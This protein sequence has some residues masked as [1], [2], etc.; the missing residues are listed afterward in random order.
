MTTRDEGVTRHEDVRTEEDV[1][2]GRTVTIVLVA[3]IAFSVLLSLASYGIQRERE[4]ALRPSGEFPEAKA[5]PPRELPGV[6]RYLFETVERAPAPNRIQREAL[7]AWSWQDPTR[8]TVNLPIGHAMRLVV[9]QGGA[10]TPTTP[11]TP[12]TSP[13]PT[14]GGTP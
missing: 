3:T 12:T 7:E 6:E 13:T 10:T 5:R 1:L 11:T 8:R 2:P 4:A 14:N 9:E